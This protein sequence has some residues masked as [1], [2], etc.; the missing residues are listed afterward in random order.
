M[1][2][3]LLELILK[4]DAGLTETYAYS[5]IYKELQPSLRIGFL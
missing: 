5:E 1:F 2:T 3:I 4:H